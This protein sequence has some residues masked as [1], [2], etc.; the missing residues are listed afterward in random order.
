MAPTTMLPL[1]QKPVCSISGNTLDK[2]SY[3]QIFNSELQPLLQ[4]FNRY[5]GIRSAKTTN[6]FDQK[7]PEPIERVNRL[8]EL[9]KD[10]AGCNGSVN[11]N[12]P[13]RTREQMID[14]VFNIR[15]EQIYLH[16]DDSRL[17]LRPES[18][19][20]LKKWATEIFAK[21]RKGSQ[22]LLIK[23]ISLERLK[24]DFLRKNEDPSIYEAILMYRLG[25]KDDKYV[26]DLWEKWMNPVTKDRIPDLDSVALEKA[27]Q[28]STSILKELLQNLRQD[29]KPVVHS[30]K[31]KY[32][33][34]EYNKEFADSNKLKGKDNHKD[35]PFFIRLSLAD[36]RSRKKNTAEQA[37]SDF[38]ALRDQLELNAGKSA[39]NGRG[40]YYDNLEVQDGSNDNIRARILGK[41]NAGLVDAYLNQPNS[42]QEEAR[43]IGEQQLREF[44]KTTK[45]IDKVYLRIA[46]R[47]MGIEVSHGF[48][49]IMI[50]LRDALSHYTV[51]LDGKT[52]I[53]QRYLEQNKLI[54]LGETEEGT[55]IMVPVSIINKYLELLNSKELEQA[56]NVDPKQNVSYDLNRLD[57]LRH[58]ENLGV[59]DGL[60]ISS[61][62]DGPLAEFLIDHYEDQKDF[63]QD[64]FDTRK[65]EIGYVLSTDSNHSLVKYL[66]A[67]LN[68]ILIPAFSQLKRSVAVATVA[69]PGKEDPDW[70]NYD[71]T[72]ALELFDALN[73][74][75]AVAN[76]GYT[77]LSPLSV[78]GSYSVSSASNDFFK[79]VYHN[80]KL[81]MGD[82]L[83]WS[84]GTDIDIKRGLAFFKAQVM[85]QKCLNKGNYIIGTGSSRSLDFSSYITDLKEAK[86]A[87]EGIVNKYPSAKDAVY[88][89]IKQLRD[90][91]EALLK[92]KLMLDKLDP[93]SSGVSSVVDISKVTRIG[94]ERVK[95]Q[96]AFMEKYFNPRDPG[97][98]LLEARAKTLEE[99]IKLGSGINYAQEE[100]LELMG[101]KK[102][103]LLSIKLTIAGRYATLLDEVPDK[104]LNT[105][106]I[107]FQRAWD[108][109]SKI[110]DL[111]EDPKKYDINDKERLSIMYY[112]AQAYK[113]LA[114][115]LR[116]MGKPSNEYKPL[117]LK[118][119]DL[120]LKLRSKA[121]RSSGKGPMQTLYE[122]GVEKWEHVLFLIAERSLVENTVLLKDIEAQVRVEPTKRPDIRNQTDGFLTEY[123][124]VI[125][126][127][128]ENIQ[129]D[130]LTEISNETEILLNKA[131]ALL[132]RLNFQEFD[133]SDQRLTLIQRITALISQVRGFINTH[134]PAV[135]A[136]GVPQVEET[137]ERILRKTD[138]IELYLLLAFAD[139]GHKQLAEVP[140]LQSL[141]ETR[142]RA[143][144]AAGV[145][146]IR[147]VDR[148]T[149]VE[150]AANSLMNMED[151]N[152]AITWANDILSY[153]DQPGRDPVT[154]KN[155]MIPIISI[156]RKA[157]AWFIKGVSFLARDNV[158]KP[159]SDYNNSIKQFQNIIDNKGSL[160][161]KGLVI[162]AYLGQVNAYIALYQRYKRIGQ[163]QN[164]EIVYNNALGILNDLINDKSSILN[165][166]MVEDE[167]FLCQRARIQFALATLHNLRT[168]RE[169]H[170]KAVGFA[171]AGLSML[172][173]LEKE[174]VD[175]QAR[176][177]KVEWDRFLIYE[178]ANVLS[179]VLRKQNKDKVEDSENSLELADVI[180]S[181]ASGETHRNTAAP[182]A[183]PNMVPIQNLYPKNQLIKGYSAIVGLISTLPKLSSINRPMGRHSMG[184]RAKVKGRFSEFD[185]ALGSVANASRYRGINVPAITG[186]GGSVLVPGG[187]Y[188]EYTILDTANL[189]LSKAEARIPKSK[190]DLQKQDRIIENQ[191][192]IDL[193]DLINKLDSIRSK[194][195]SV[196][197]QRDLYLV[198]ALM[199]L[200][201]TIPLTTAVSTTVVFPSVTV[202]GNTISSLDD[203]LMYVEA[204]LNT[205]ISIFVS[206]VLLLNEYRLALAAFYVRMDRYEEAK[207]QFVSV[208]TDCDSELSN[209]ATDFVDYHTDLKI[210]LNWARLGL[211][212][213]YQ[214]Y[215][216]GQE[217]ELQNGAI[218]NHY[219]DARKLYESVIKDAEGIDSNDT[220]NQIINA[221]LG[222]GDLY[223]TSNQDEINAKALEHF[224]IAVNMLLS[225]KYVD[226][227]TIAWVIP[228]I[229]PVLLRLKAERRQALFAAPTATASGITINNQP[230]NAALSKRNDPDNPISYKKPD[231]MMNV[232]QGAG[233]KK[234][235]MEYVDAFND[236]N[237]VRKYLEVE[238]NNPNR[239]ISLGDYSIYLESRF[240]QA[241]I[242]VLQ[243][244]FDEA[245]FILDQILLDLDNM[246]ESRKASPQRWNIAWQDK[247][248]IIRERIR[249]TR[250][251]ILIRNEDIDTA[252]NVLQGAVVKKDLDPLYSGLSSSQQTTVDNLF[253]PASLTADVWIFKDATTSVDIQSLA[254][255][256]VP[257]PLIDVLIKS[258]KS[259][260]VDFVKEML[261]LKKSLGLPIDKF[262]RISIDRIVRQQEAL[263]DVAVD[264]IVNKD[265]GVD[266][267]RKLFTALDTLIF[268][269]RVLIEQ[270]ETLAA[271][272][273]L[274]ISVAPYVCKGRV[275]KPAI[276]ADVLDNKVAFNDILLELRAQGILD[277]S[278]IVTP[279]AK[280]P[281]TL[282]SKNKVRQAR[283]DK[284]SETE[285][286][287]IES[288]MNAILKRIR[289]GFHIDNMRQY[290]TSDQLDQLERDYFI[291]RS[292]L[293]IRDTDYPGAVLDYE[294]AMTSLDKVHDPEQKMS[295]YLGY[296]EALTLAGNK[297]SQKKLLG[298]LKNQLSPSKYKNS[299]ERRVWQVNRPYIDMLRGEMYRLKENYKKAGAEYQKATAYPRYTV[300]PA[301]ATDPA[302]NEKNT[303]RAY[304]KGL[305]REIET[306][307]E[308]KKQLKPSKIANIINIVDE[309]VIKRTITGNNEY[310]LALSN[311]QSEALLIRGD[312]YFA[313]EDY[314]K[315]LADYRAALVKDQGRKIKNIVVYQRMFKLH[316][317]ITETEAKREAIKKDKLARLEFYK[318]VEAMRLKAK[319]VTKVP[320]TDP[321]LGQAVDSLVNYILK[322]GS[323]NRSNPVKGLLT[324]EVISPKHAVGY[325]DHDID[326]DSVTTEVLDLALESVA[327]LMALGDPRGL[328]LY[329]GLMT[330]AET[331][332]KPFAGV[333]SNLL[334]DEEVTSAATL[335]FGGFRHWLADENGVPY[336]LV[337]EEGSGEETLCMPEDGENGAVVFSAAT[338]TQSWYAMSLAWQDLLI[339]GPYIHVPELRES[340]ATWFASLA[341]DT[342][343][344]GLVAF[345]LTVSGKFN[346]GKLENV[347]VSGIPETLV[348][349]QSPTQAYLFGEDDVVD[350]Q[351]KLFQGAAKNGFFI[352][353]YKFATGKFTMDSGDL[354]E[355]S[356]GLALFQYRSFRELAKYYLLS[357]DSR[358]LD[359]CKSFIKSIKDDP[360]FSKGLLPYELDEDGNVDEYREGDPHDHA[361]YLQG[362]TYLE[363]AGASIKDLSGHR[364][365]VNKRLLEIQK[366]S[367]NGSFQDQDGVAYGFHQMEALIAL[368]LQVLLDLGKFKDID[369]K[370]VTYRNRFKPTVFA[371]S[372]NTTDSVKFPNIHRERF[373][374]ELQVVKSPTGDLE[375]RGSA[376]E[377]QAGAVGVIIPDDLSAHKKLYIKVDNAIEGTKVRFEING[378]TWTIPVYK[379]EFILDLEKHFGF[380]GSLGKNT[381]MRIVLQSQESD[382][383]A[384]AKFSKIEF[385][386]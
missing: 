236:Y 80:P 187:I 239:Y 44:N 335:E 350:R 215:A 210:Q 17:F 242:R 374:Q 384:G 1:F 254:S 255:L 219:T 188:R 64:T 379:G 353:G 283:F 212:N 234:A 134:L 112:A 204:I 157:S 209:P 316:K 54:K 311:S 95:S 159:V 4:D 340:K 363:A 165:G 292:Q 16:N 274:D 278:N 71:T 140:E 115:L 285:K 78:T 29:G 244:K 383:T 328:Q 282:K 272:E 156:D 92:L 313:L 105:Y 127:F 287:I 231:L 46:F 50:N 267:G 176:S 173:Q 337:R 262:K 258:S 84:T 161:N 359:L 9:T 83:G 67:E 346:N 299:L 113:G 192:Q 245:L 184:P 190:A 330:L 240:A 356:P 378:R 107:Y 45:L 256:G 38:K 366:Y 349:Y 98:T 206:N 200:P 224:K 377:Y 14:L 15:S 380:T 199:L 69:T 280:L 305:I 133:S 351:I 96:L 369:K 329:E 279:M 167:M 265:M 103:Q 321:E 116:N 312:L 226:Y 106:R 365:V 253:E 99:A 27:L 297:R 6:P 376:D 40:E 76:P 131:Y 10:A 268:M 310:D 250:I 205:G 213:L 195:P 355:E 168:K 281:F 261:L 2:K 81:I 142:I 341:M 30:T 247:L 284:L 160:K 309:K 32:F 202:N 124:R 257:Q 201:Q 125:Q 375:L 304:F 89:Q 249:T 21:D 301:L 385:Q 352:M 43:I 251:M 42:N 82:L 221:H 130:V 370:A 211:A 382:G 364:K 141:I 358:A 177:D 171:T 372:S 228:S 252:F 132:I 291:T 238:R 154:S 273:L 126:R 222:L 153:T 110:I 120:L 147:I 117:I 326:P 293:D 170:K 39:P 339:P 51:E 155:V 271:E 327:M 303:W 23:M 318:K 79:F 218:T 260:S 232:F 108:K 37:V 60:T 225:H 162:S 100:L 198:K 19:E 186:S 77:A 315:A 118:S 13:Y 129:A 65:D 300:V 381:L 266:Y 175:D 48:P 360:K 361:V 47:L 143:V 128:K 178:G 230:H 58:Y 207:D 295:I 3:G 194:D 85:Y 357:R 24:N 123:Y 243:G 216:K 56:R 33:L 288:S 185:E 5:Y 57:Q 276:L 298:L 217:V 179:E 306:L 323:F 102:D 191:M 93:P 183:T 181:L 70:A 109:Y 344:L 114:A 208:I 121:D 138:Q 25:E 8:F 139:S 62:V 248:E 338:D 18:V 319:G 101:G 314:D 362:L 347:T 144:N 61:T 246:E 55:P 148:T 320:I 371:A 158:F 189:V 31:E 277:S 367:G 52:R 308:D 220:E 275:L 334:P 28:N 302:F 336:N 331:S 169:D 119:T 182:S 373:G 20:L 88:A 66:R 135:R 75:Y 86:I 227:E 296:G 203:L 146:D 259:A 97:L 286:G 90:A 348:A 22:D 94:V 180:S 214:L 12:V 263:L 87:Y 322:L 7:L 149:Y 233:L 145:S 324:I 174:T 343:N 63:H 386:K 150:I 368:Q 73:A 166:F 137:M 163:H 307:F 74:G 235:N 223:N 41:I 53:A 294:F 35:L 68:L 342:K 72:K 11:V 151:F 237:K 122:A 264:S 345:D 196:I 290:L 49:E 91:R 172:V 270:G 289:K 164:A 241:D 136:A 26:L 152:A 193:I 269:T 354:K 197:A 229:K 111:Y 59:F 332:M 34:G 104:D 333:E 325:I 317:R 36:L